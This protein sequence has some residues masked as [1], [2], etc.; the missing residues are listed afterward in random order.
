M[1]HPVKFFDEHITLLHSVQ[2]DNNGSRQGQE[3]DEGSEIIVI[4]ILILIV[5]IIV[6]IFI[7]NADNNGSRQSQPSDEKL[8]N[9]YCYWHPIGTLIL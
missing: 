2:A 5:I 1:A 7:I 8:E 3:P 4:V 9:E 6:I